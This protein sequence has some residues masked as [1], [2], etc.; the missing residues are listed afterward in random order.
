MIEFL[1][2]FA[3]YFFA[4]IGLITCATFFVQWMDEKINDDDDPPRS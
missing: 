3:L 2:Y 1:G 4:V